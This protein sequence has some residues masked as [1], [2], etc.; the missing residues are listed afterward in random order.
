[1]QFLI[2]HNEEDRVELGE[3]PEL[4]EGEVPGSVD[5]SSELE[6]RIPLPRASKATQKN[7]NESMSQFQKEKP[8]GCSNKRASR[9][10]K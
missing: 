1:M 8:H 7:Q 4:E 2:I 6:K 5:L 10:K 9:K 3:M